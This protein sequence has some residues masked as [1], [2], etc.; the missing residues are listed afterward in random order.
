MF[1]SANVRRDT[2]C[3]VRNETAQGEYQTYGMIFELGL[4]FLHAALPLGVLSMH[5]PLLLPQ[6]TST[7]Q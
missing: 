5:R 4:P 7:Q 6:G 1:E 2:C 3:A